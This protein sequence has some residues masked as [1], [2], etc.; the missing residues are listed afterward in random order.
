[1]VLIPAFAVYLYAE[2]LLRQGAISNIDSSK[3][4]IDTVIGELPESV[5]DAVS[6]RIHYG[7]LQDAIRT[8]ANDQE[9][10]YALS[11]M[12]AFVKEP[13]KRIELYE[14]VVKRYGKIPESYQAFVFFLNNFQSK[15]SI[16]VPQYHQYVKQFS[17]LDQYYIWTMG[18]SKLRQMQTPEKE[19]FNF[20]QPL[21]SYKPEYRDYSGLYRQIAELAAKLGMKEDYRRAVKLEEACL[22]RPLLE[23]VYVERMEKAQQEK[24]Q[25]AK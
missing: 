2:S 12:A 6:Y 1:M 3:F 24:K 15:P 10:A 25:P 21:L 8:A 22:D 14:Q 17:L 5:K 7:Q 13:E 19:L 4:N 20:L 9:M 18:L 16:T 23:T 11:A